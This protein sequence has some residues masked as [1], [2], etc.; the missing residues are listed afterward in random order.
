MTTHHRL[1]IV[2]SGP[3]GYTA[4]IYAARANLEP[5]V[6]AG[7]V[8]AGGELMNTTDVENFPGFPEGVQGPDLMENMRAQAERFGA[9]VVYDD[10]TELDLTPGAHSIVTALGT[11]YTAEAVILATGSA[12]RELGLPNEKNLTGHGVSWCA[13]CDGF[14]FRD[15][16]IAVIGGGDSAMEEATF[17]SRFASKVTVVHRRQELRASQAMQDRVINDPKIEFLFDSEVAEVHGEDSLTGLTIRSTVTGETTELPVTGMFVAIGSDPRTSLFD[18]QL[19]LRED[20]YLHVDGRSSRTSIEGVFAAGDVIDPV[21]R[22]AI[23]SAGSGC[24]AALDAEHYL[25]D[26]AQAVQ[27]EAAAAEPVAQPQAA[28][29]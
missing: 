15:H 2:G 7:S 17:L 19:Q 12:Y 20:G 16:H 10:V 27:S 13:T 18:Q 4:A 6:I 26:R 11:R 25:A 9:T 1:I 21:Y 29:A 8:T 28:N 14:F 22:Q 23:T 3:A 24:S 5:L